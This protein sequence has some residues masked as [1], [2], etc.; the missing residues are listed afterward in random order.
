MFSLKDRKGFTIVEVMIVLAIAGAI[1]LI[2]FLAVP[3]L[4]RNSRN[5]QM[6]ND[7][8][9][10]LAG[11]SEYSSNNNGILPKA[12]SVSSGEVTFSGGQGSTTVSSSINVRGDTQVTLATSAPVSFPT[13]PGSVVIAINFKC[14][15]NSAVSASNRATA[16][17]FL[18]ETASNTATQCVDS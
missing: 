8:A 14:N 17:L 15:G 6:R 3:A 5:T 9:S 10:L 18:V 2:V 13:V 11:V 1:L 4:Q 7:V 12:V 16:G